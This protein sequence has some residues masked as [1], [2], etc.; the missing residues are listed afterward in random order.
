MPRMMGF[1]PSANEPEYAMG[2][3]GTAS[4]NSAAGSVQMEKVQPESKARPCGRKH[5]PL[6]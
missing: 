3:V 4:T 1:W 5:S 6:A 2:T